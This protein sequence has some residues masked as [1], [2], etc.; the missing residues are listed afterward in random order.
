[1]AERYA[2]K[3]RILFHRRGFTHNYRDSFKPEFKGKG[4]AFID[5][6]FIED[7]NYGAPMLDAAR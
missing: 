6:Y 5:V 7:P 1:V 4:A 2:A 3:P